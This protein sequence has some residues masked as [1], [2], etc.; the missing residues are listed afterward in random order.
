M[1]IILF[2][3]IFICIKA[4]DNTKKEILEALK[5]DINI[6]VPCCEEKTNA[7]IT[8][9]VNPVAKVNKKAKSAKINKPLS[10]QEPLPAVTEPQPSSSPP[11]LFDVIDAM[12]SKIDK[13]S[14]NNSASY[15]TWNT[16]EGDTIQNN[17]TYID[18]CLSN[19][20]YCYDCNGYEVYIHDN[21]YEEACKDCDKEV[22]EPMPLLL[23]GT[24]LIAIST[25]KLKLKK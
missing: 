17:T 6:T 1:S 11:Y 20:R 3:I 19:G 8:P 16:W 2:V 12:N 23:V 18:G 14:E 13:L 9:T 4:C 7:A 25:L 24:G 22:P 21:W 15:N 10:Q 5:K